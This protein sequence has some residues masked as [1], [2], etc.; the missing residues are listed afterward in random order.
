MNI[1]TIEKATLSLEEQCIEE[2]LDV[3]LIQ[4]SQQCIDHGKPQPQVHSTWSSSAG[5][6]IPHKPQIEGEEAVNKVMVENIRTNS[7]LNVLFV[8]NLDV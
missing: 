6:V 1:A 7:I 3:Y 4:P 2:S 8:I 5:K